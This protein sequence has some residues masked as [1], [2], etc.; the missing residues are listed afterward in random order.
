MGIEKRVSDL[1]KRIGIGVADSDE[2][3]CPSEPGVSGRRVVYACKEPEEATAEDLE[4]AESQ[5]DRVEVCAVCARP[6]PASQVLLTKHWRAT[7]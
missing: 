2:C 5:S 6:R 1:E 4:W 7:D 3:T